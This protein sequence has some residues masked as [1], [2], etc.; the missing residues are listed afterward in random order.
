MS[1]TERVL[2]ALRANIE[3]STADTSA[4]RPGT[5]A[6]VYLDN[7]KPADVTATSF[8]ACLAA[9]AKQGLYRVIDGFA[10]GSVRLDDANA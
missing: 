6:D 2:A 10:W 7:A 3:S 8:R 1:T 9:L 5:W 4:T